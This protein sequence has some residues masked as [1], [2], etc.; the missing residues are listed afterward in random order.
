MLGLSIGDIYNE[1]RKIIRISGRLKNICHRLKKQVTLNTITSQGTRT[2]LTVGVPFLVFCKHC[3]RPPPLLNNDWTNQIRFNPL[4]IQ[5]IIRYL[6]GDYKNGR[7]YQNT[8]K[9]NNGRSNIN[10]TSCSYT[11]IS[12]I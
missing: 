10:S 8:F 5:N 9:A 7:N 1:F 3:I 4:H 6:K 12:K 2:E 11:R